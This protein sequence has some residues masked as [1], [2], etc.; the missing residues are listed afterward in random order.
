MGETIALVTVGVLMVGTWVTMLIKMVDLAKIVGQL[1]ERME[2]LK[3][4]C[5][6]SLEKQVDTLKTDL[7]D[8]NN[9]VHENHQQLTKDIYEQNNKMHEN[10]IELLKILAELK[11][12]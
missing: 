8:L 5:F 12:R 11:N 2:S 9:K 3:S 7:K 4:N 1:D 6:A 10:H